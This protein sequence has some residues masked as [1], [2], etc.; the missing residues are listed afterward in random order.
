NIRPN[1]IFTADAHIILYKLGTLKNEKV[2]EVINKI[3]LI[4]KS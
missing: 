4:I 3:I 2:E 1:R